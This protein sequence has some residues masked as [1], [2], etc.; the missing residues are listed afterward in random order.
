MRHARCSCLLAMVGVLGDM[1]MSN[2]VNA[3]VDSGG[4]VPVQLGRTE[5]CEV[6]ADVVLKAPRNEGVRVLLHITKGER[7]G[8]ERKIQTGQHGV[9]LVSWCVEFVFNSSK[10]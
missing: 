8:D 4:S 7:G 9:C 6:H 3:R 5:V 2:G 10:Q 1:V